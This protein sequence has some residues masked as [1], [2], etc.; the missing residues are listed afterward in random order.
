MDAVPPPRVSLE[1]QAQP[2]FR[3]NHTPYITELP[4]KHSSP[5][6]RVLFGLVTYNLPCTDSCIRA[7]GNMR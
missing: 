1:I 5:Q 2:L 3:T 6:R 7:R 4:C